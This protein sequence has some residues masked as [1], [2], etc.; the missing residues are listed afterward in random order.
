M[1]EMNYKKVFLLWLLSPLILIGWALADNEHREFMKSN[2]AAPFNT[3]LRRIVIEPGQD[4][5]TVPLAPLQQAQHSEHEKPI[6]ETKEI[7]AAN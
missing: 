4:L 1:R 2:I 7:C 3:A 6:L 5:P